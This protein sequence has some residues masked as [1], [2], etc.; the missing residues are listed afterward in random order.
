M[1]MPIVP[2]MELSSFYKIRT[3]YE[4][5]ARARV[6]ER[7][8]HGDDTQYAQCV[9]EEM[10]MDLLSQVKV[11]AEEVSKLKALIGVE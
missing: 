10:A 2:Q 7:L 9:L 8:N 1:P 11:L 6:E 5:R 4:A 3:G